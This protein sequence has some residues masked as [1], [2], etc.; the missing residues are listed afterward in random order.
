M[1]GLSSDILGLSIAEN[2]NS[3]CRQFS[4]SRH[5]QAPLQL[6]EEDAFYWSSG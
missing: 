5:S 3:C 2:L 1:V 6:I 4:Y